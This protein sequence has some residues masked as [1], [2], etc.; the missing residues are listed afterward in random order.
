MVFHFP[1]ISGGGVVVIT[2]IINKFVES[3][4]D[5][6]VITPDIEWNGEQYDPKIDSKIRV[7][8]T[9]TP[10]KSRIKVAARRCQANI[11]KQAIEI[12]KQEKFDFV[13]TIFHP[14]HLVPKAAVETAKELQ[15]PSIVKI[16]DAIYERSTGIKSLQRKIEKIINSKTLRTATKVLVS[17]ND[18]SEII[19]NEYGVLPEKIA[20]IPN[21]VD[22]SLFN[23]SSQKNP[24]KVVF[25]GAMYH[26]RGLDVFLEAI[27]KIIKKIPDAKFI[28]LGSGNELE[29]LKD[30]VS[31]KKLENSVEFKGWIRREKIPENISDAAIGIGPLR[32]TSVT[33][34]ALPIKVLEYMATS[35]PIIAQKGTLPNDVLVNEKNGYFIDGA[36][37]LAGKISS[38][39]NESEK[40][41]Q[42]G[43]QS[44]LMVEKFSWDNIIKNILEIVKKN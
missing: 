17:N 14:F 32:L 21:G 23:S 26:H 15:I 3:G 36:E 29:K 19:I 39:L 7:I 13:F 5:V 33:S 11:K 38:L 6:T 20:I 22:L 25:V 44:R 16:D 9:E 24:K 37:D 40:I 34:R 12:G 27:P 8:R 41:N 18:T 1:P 28:L 2:D 42:M 4:N 10:S 30:I 43:S 31:A 35:L